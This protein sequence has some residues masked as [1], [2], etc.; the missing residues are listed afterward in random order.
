MHRV[1]QE[2]MT[3]ALTDKYT[4][5]NTLVENVR[6]EANAEINDLKN[7][8][9]VSLNDR[10]SLGD[11][12][13]ELVTA[14]KEKVLAQQQLQQMYN[15]LKSRV[16]A[17]AVEDAAKHTEESVVQ[18]LTCPNRNGSFRGPQRPNAA[19]V[20]S[21][22]SPTMSTHDRQG[23]AGSGGQHNFFNDQGHHQNV[24]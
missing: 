9:M 10:K 5:L 3:R 19:H 4:Q 7:Q 13:T 18:G 1:Y 24:T 14:Y 15:K 2:H 11:R 6:N 16:N 12:N 21:Q 23:S 22:H 17:V 8:L 20:R